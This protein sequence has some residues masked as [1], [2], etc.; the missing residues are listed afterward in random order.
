MY[1]KT[2]RPS[3]YKLPKKCWI[4]KRMKLR[5]EFYKDSTRADK[6]SARCKECDKLCNTK[7]KYHKKRYVEV[8]KKIIK[9]LGNK[10]VRCGFTD[11]RAL[12]IDHVNGDGANERRI[13]GN[14]RT[15]YP[16]ILNKIEKGSKDYQI[17]CA[18]CN[19]IKRHE[20][21]EYSKRKQPRT[22]K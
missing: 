4:C 5:T 8:R 15:Y 18:N 6:K 2:M 1:N 22:M 10:C 17:L 19:W 13:T 11:A 14:T 3:Q 20:N 21:K 16:H 7:P 9:L 12:Q